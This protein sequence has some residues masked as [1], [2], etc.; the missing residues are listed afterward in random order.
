MPSGK[1]SF[2]KTLLEAFLLVVI[3]FELWIGLFF[4]LS[5]SRAISLTILVLSSPTTSEMHSLILILDLSEMNLISSL[6]YF[7]LINW[8]LANSSIVLVSEF[9]QVS[10]NL[11]FSISIMY[12]LWVNKWVEKWSYKIKSFSSK[13]FWAFIL[14]I[15]L[16]VFFHIL[17]NFHFLNFLKK[18]N[19]LIW[20]YESLSI[21]HWPRLKNS[22][23]ISFS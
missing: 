9:V 6:I 3:V 16:I 7:V 21:S 23:G 14:C 1:P 22:I 17:M 19:S 10:T 2:S 20:L 5:S 8:R 4:F 15:C 18:S 11:F 12:F 13:A